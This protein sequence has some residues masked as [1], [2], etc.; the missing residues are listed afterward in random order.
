VSAHNGALFTLLPKQPRIVR[1]ELNAAYLAAV[2]PGMK[3]QVLDDGDSQRV[4]GDAHVLRLAQVFG[5]STQEDDPEV[6]AN[7]RTVEC[8]LAFD[9]PSALRIGQ[10]V[11]VR[12]LGKAP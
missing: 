9:R 5:P 12:F 2:T 11:L 4:L 6:R 7:E 10:R 1:A 8:V 3:A